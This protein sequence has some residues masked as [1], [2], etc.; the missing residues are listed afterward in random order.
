MKISGMGMT[1]KWE[2][3][4]NMHVIIVTHKIK[5]WDMQFT[6]RKKVNVLEMKY[7]KSMTGVIRRNRI[8][9]D[10]LRIKA[11]GKKEMV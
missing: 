10:I 6:K 3:N 7:Q 1:A 11:D 2:L 8:I 9:N 5:L 4:E